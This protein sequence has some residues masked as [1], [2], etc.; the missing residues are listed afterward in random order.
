MTVKIYTMLTKIYTML[1]KIYTMLT[2]V[3]M[4]CRELIHPYIYNAH[5]E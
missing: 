4:N 3:L 1:T 5:I 2:K